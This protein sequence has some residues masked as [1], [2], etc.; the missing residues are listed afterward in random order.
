MFFSS[1]VVSDSLWPH[2]LQHARLPCPS[3]FPGVCSS[4]W[5]YPTI[6]SSISFSF[7]PQSFPESVFS[8]EERGTKGFRPVGWC[9]FSFFLFSLGV[10]SQVSLNLL[11]IFVLHIFLKRK[12]SRHLTLNSRDM[13]NWMLNVELVAKQTCERG[14]SA[15]SPAI[16]KHLD[17]HLGARRGTQNPKCWPLWLLEH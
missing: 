9:S 6:S 11:Q 3:L 15:W 1:Y 14:A 13:R 2:G 12:R 7:Y 17:F 10:F 4:W 8:N 16:Q 5:L